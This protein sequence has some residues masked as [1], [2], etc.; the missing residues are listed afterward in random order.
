MRASELNCPSARLPIKE[1]YPDCTHPGR[2]LDT[3]IN[4]DECEYYG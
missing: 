1:Y 2:E 4:S 3:L